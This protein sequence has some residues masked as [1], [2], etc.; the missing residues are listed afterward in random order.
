MPDLLVII[1]INPGSDRKIKKVKYPLVILKVDKGF[2]LVYIRIYEYNLDGGG[3][4][5]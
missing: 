2:V 1:R 5:F 3:V 4:S